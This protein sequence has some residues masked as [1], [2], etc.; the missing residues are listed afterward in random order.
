[1]MKRFPR[2]RWL[3]LLASLVLVPVASFAGDTG[4]REWTHTEGAPGG[5]RYSP[6]AEIHA[7]NVARLVPVWSYRDGDVKEARLRPD[8]VNRSS[9]FEGTPIV[10]GGRL[11]VSTP[12]DR[13][14]ALDVETGA[15]LWTHDPAIDRERFFANMLISRGVAYW[16]G[17]EQGP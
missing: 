11:F 9:A 2:P 6:L 7:G 3:P 8:R 4:G 1:M 10:V 14:I 16:N 12:F 5:G 15:E 17:Q 13:V